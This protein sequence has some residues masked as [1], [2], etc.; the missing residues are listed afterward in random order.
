VAT[1]IKVI[2]LGA[3]D[4]EHCREAAELHI[5]TIHHGLLPLLGRRFLKKM[6]LCIAE[7]PNSGVWAVVDDQGKLRGFVAGCASVQRTYR[8]LIMNHGLALAVTA[9]L[10]LF[11]FGVLRKLNSILSYP[12]HPRTSRDNQASGAEL[13]AIAIDAGE[14]RKGYGTELVRTLE[15]SLLQW[16]V[17]KYQVVTNTAE[18]ESNAFYRATGFI[19]AG[20]I[21]HHALTLQVYEKPIAN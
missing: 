19:P 15:A 11:R 5:R 10:N 16:G 4:Y 18:T 12:F 13:L 6:Y 17:K 2:R 8:S 7:A 3:K 20:T 9:G 1:P 21:K 14:Y